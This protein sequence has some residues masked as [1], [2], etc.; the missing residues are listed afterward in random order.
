MTDSSPRVPRS[1]GRLGPRELLVHETYRSIQGESTWAG[2]PCFFIRL[3]GCHLRCSWCDTTHAF[4]GGER[5]DIETCLREAADSGCELVEVTGGEPLLQ[6]AA[7][8]LL[9]GLCDRGHRVLLE[10]SGTLPIDGI[11]P[12]VTR[13]VDWKAPASAEAPRQHPGLANQLRPGDE[14]KIVVADRRDY[15]WSRD[16]IVRGELAPVL[17]RGGIPIQLS[18]AF[19]RLKERELASW[20]LEDSLAVRLNVQLHK[21]VWP[22]ET[23]GV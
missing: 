12:R 9:A 23:R 6:K 3:S 2:W 11:D 8:A 16:L 7:P 1:P 4:H 17:A 20:I 13:I 14:V 10:T 15:E 21:H 5:R 19:G 22:P 18:A